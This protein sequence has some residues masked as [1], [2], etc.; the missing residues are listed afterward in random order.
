MRRSVSIL[1]ALL[2]LLLLPAGAL[3]ANSAKSST[4][5]LASYSG[6]VTVTDGN[7]KGVAVSSGLRLYSGYT[8]ATKAG[9]AAAVK[10]DNSKY[11]KL[12]ANTK[13]SVRQSGGKL[14]IY[15]V[16]GTIVCNVTSPW[17][18]ARA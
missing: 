2:V 16:S 4:L 14:E 17:A 12:S 9:S 7:G 6:T 1:L 5:S 18:P 15:L 11:V 3:A 13:A 10:L 8:V